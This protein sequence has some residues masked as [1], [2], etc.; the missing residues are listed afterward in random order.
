V[1]DQP[2][3]AFVSASRRTVLYIDDNPANLLLVE[4]LFA[5]RPEIE[6]VTAARGLLGLEMARDRQPALVL[7]D[8]HLPDVNGDRVLKRLHEDPLTRAIP[9]VV[10]SADAS[11]R[12]I[13]R[14][15]TCGAAAYLTKPLDLRRLVDLV[16]EIIGE[17]T[18]A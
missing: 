11:E 5:G 7:L 17:Q 16:D 18:S 12:Q 1:L 6:L 3:E 8:I 2:T 4:R 13:E 9:V 14:L 15:L 10:L